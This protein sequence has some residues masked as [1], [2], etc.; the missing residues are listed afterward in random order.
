MVTYSDFQ[1]KYPLS[2]KKFW[3]KIIE[4][5]VPG[6]F[7]SIGLFA[8]LF[9]APIIIQ[10]AVKNYNGYLTLF[11]FGL[12]LLAI[13]VAF[14]INIVYIHYYIKYYFYDC[15]DQF[16]TIKKDPITP[17]EIHVQYNKIQ[18]VYVD[19]DLIDRILDIYDVHIASA[20]ISSGIEAHI[21]GVDHEEAEAI[22]TFLLNKLKSS[23]NNTVSMNQD[24]GGGKNEKNDNLVSIK[25]DK[26]IS[27]NEYPV[28]NSYIFSIMFS[29]VFF[30]L[31][32][33]LL[34]MGPLL[35]ITK[36]GVVFYYV[37]GVIFS[38]ILLM[39]T[40]ILWIRAFYFEFEQDYILCKTGFI[41]KS[42]THIPYK[43][44]QNVT[45][46]QGIFDRIFHI[47]NIIIENAAQGLIAPMLLFGQPEGK[48]DEITNVLNG[49][50]KKI[51]RTNNS[52]NGL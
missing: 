3:K 50:L 30:S 25:L 37:S 4:S 31:F 19:Q 36:T 22:K 5:I 26:K 7:K 21:D 27:S 28:S 1:T 6:I 11:F 20:T 15:N 44:I 29:R 52:T 42:E 51:N 8:L 45:T 24:S 14:I 17:R 9:V 38:F 47:K 48:A 12:A 40:Q 35:E 41:A 18:D 43:N 16:I 32:I 39:V 34:F 23:S 46:S 13:L 2:K 49:L 33:P 10:G